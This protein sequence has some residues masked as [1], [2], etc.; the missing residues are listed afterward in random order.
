MAWLG[1]LYANIRHIRPGVWCNF[2]LVF[3]IAVSGNVAAAF[4]FPD[5]GHTLFLPF[6]AAAAVF[7]VMTVILYLNAGRFFIRSLRSLSAVPSRKVLIV[8]VSEQQALASDACVSRFPV[9]LTFPGRDDRTLSGDLECDVEEVLRDS[10]WSGQQ[11][12]RAIRTHRDTL[13]RIILV[14]S[15]A[16]ATDAFVSLLTAYKEKGGLRYGARTS[17]PVDFE[18]FDAVSNVLRG[19]IGRLR[20]EGYVDA[21]IVIDITGGQ[22]PNSIAAAAVTLEYGDILFQYVKTG[23]DHTVVA[24]DIGIHVPAQHS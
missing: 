22:K 6:L 12:L 17:V 20:K 13:E 24:Y 16:S 10:R 1:H 4:L 18:D 15:Q 21:D 19:E 9:T 23:G 14:G 7:F 3:V 8:F 2:L 11:M 5:S